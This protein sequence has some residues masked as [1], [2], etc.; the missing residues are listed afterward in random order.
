LEKEITSAKLRK[1]GEV[2]RVNRPPLGVRELEFRGV[3]DKRKERG[4][5]RERGRGNKLK[6]GE[7]LNVHAEESKE[8]E[9]T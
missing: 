3:A 2:L 6:K 8:K 5:F 4:Q 9:R 7:Y 1:G